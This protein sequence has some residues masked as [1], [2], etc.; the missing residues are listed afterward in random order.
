LITPDVWTLFV[1]GQKSNT[2]GF[3]DPLTGVFE[4]WKTFVERGRRAPNLILKVLHKNDLKT[5]R[6]DLNPELLAS[7]NEVMEQND[8]G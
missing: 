7:A 6:D 8:N 3:K 2:W 1:T 5:L 4:H